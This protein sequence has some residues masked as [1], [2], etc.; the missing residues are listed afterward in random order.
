[1][2]TAQA[3]VVKW[4]SHRSSEPLVGVR[5]PPGAHCG[6]GLVVECVLAKDETRVRFSLPAQF[7]NCLL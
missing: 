5:V 7:V 6:Y 1:M 4:I 2:H 3:P